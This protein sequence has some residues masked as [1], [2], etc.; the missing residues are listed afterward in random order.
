MSTFTSAASIDAAAVLHRRVFPTGL[1]PVAVRYSPAVARA[2]RGNATAD[3]YL[4][5]AAGS[6]TTFIPL[7]AASATAGNGHPGEGN[8]GDERHS[9]L[10]DLPGWGESTHGTSA[11]SLT[12]ATMAEAVTGILWTLGYRHW[13]LIGHSMG[14]FLALEIAAAEPKRTASV[15]VI[16]GATFSVATAAAHPLPGLLRFPA[17]TAMLLLMR[18]MAACGPVGEF[19]VRRTG[20]SP[21]MRPL[22]SPF[23]SHPHVIDGTV[24][25]ALGEDARPAAFAAAARAAAGYD[26]SR[27]RGITA[28]VLAVRGLRDVFTPPSDLVRLAELVPHVRLVTIPGCGHFA[29]IE[30][31]G[32][33]AGLLAQY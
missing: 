24:I 33:L 10:M 16:S 21:L 17:F 27:W 2:D 12:M 23:F 26:F 15:A 22:M 13:N 31:P 1:G 6:W 7:L 4:H 19:L 18:A 5:G 8:P 3:V 28:P 14:A 9:V 20:R 30:Q 25:T 32:F 29:P 11:A